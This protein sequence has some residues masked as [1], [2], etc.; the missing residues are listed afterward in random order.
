MAESE[1]N[2]QHLVNQFEKACARRKLKVNANK[3][4]VMV[5]STVTNQGVVKIQ[6]NGEILEEVNSFRY[7]GSMVSRGSGVHVDVKHKIM[8]GRAVCGALRRVWTNRKLGMDVKKV[9]Y[10]GIVVPTVLY[11]G[12]TWGLKVTERKKLNV[13][14]MNCL[15]SMCGVNRRDRV[16]NEDIRQRVGICHELAERVDMKVLSWYG[17]VMRMNE[18]RLTLRVYESKV[19]G[20]R[21]RGRPKMSWR[22]GVKKAL[23][24]RGLDEANSMVLC[25]EKLE[26]RHFVRC[27]RA[28]EVEM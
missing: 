21:G 18:S 26:W 2:L 10:E 5:C 15:R 28:D 20:Y 12:E 27:I 23:I 22:E 4:K 7:L 1:E 19:E 25:K 24:V 8:Q 13:M 16:R 17:H 6:L 11:G 3:S 14:E 9:L